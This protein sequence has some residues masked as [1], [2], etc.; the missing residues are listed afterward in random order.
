VITASKAVNLL[1]G[2]VIEGLVQLE[3]YKLFVHILTLVFVYLIIVG[4]F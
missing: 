2:H 4:V 1:D 3:G